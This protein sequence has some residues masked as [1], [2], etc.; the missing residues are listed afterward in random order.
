MDKFSHKKAPV[1]RK[2]SGF[3]IRSLEAQQDRSTL[4]AVLER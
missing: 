4:R 1:W 2:E 3:P